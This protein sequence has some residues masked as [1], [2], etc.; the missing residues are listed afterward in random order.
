KTPG[1]APPSEVYA[2]AGAWRMADPVDN[3]ARGAWWTLFQDAELDALEAKVGDANQNI[4]AAFARLQE[5]RA[6]TR[7]ARA[8]LFPTLTVGSSAARSRTSVNSPDFPTGAEPVGNNFDLQADLSYEVD[9]WGR[10]RNAVNSAKASQQ[11]SA[12]D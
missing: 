7:I 1:S 9:V 11:A 10:V 6:A 4:K 2:E 3:R 5:P 12:A 8:D